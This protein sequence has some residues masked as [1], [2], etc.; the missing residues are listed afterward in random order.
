MI[1]TNQGKTTTY[2][3]G[4]GEGEVEMSRI[5]RV[6]ILWPDGFEP[7]YGLSLGEVQELVF[8][9]VMNVDENE[10]D[11]LGLI[12]VLLDAIRRSHSPTT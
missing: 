12:S 9:I 3:P 6:L 5:G 2:R 1:D 10:I 11:D 4:R 7:P 8:D